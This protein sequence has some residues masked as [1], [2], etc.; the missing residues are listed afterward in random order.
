MPIVTLTTDFGLQ[1]WFVGSMRGVMLGINPDLTIVDL[2]HGICG[3]DIPGGALA[4]TAGYHCFPPG[5]IH[6]A[7]V[8]PGVGS[9]RTA[10]AASIPDHFFIGP[11][12]GLFALV[13]ARQGKVSLR[14][15]DDIRWH[16]HPVSSTFHGRDIFAPAAAHLSRGIPF[17]ALGSAVTS[18]QTLNWPSV[19]RNQ[20]EMRG[21]VVYVDHF[22]N[23]LTNIHAD[24]LGGEA[25]QNVYL[26][27]GSLPLIPGQSFYQ[28]VDCGC[29]LVLIGSSGYLE[30]AVNGGRACDHLGL[31]RESKV[32]LTGKF[33]PLPD[34]NKT[35]ND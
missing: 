24:H 9:E 23:C 20:S 30:I 2:T 11:D 12:N 22:G 6:V 32:V 25:I 8:D 19:T 4:L 7:V 3:G 21:A 31:R 27:I 13:L 17:E 15:L 5:T 16:R 10:L 29:P 18:F 34:K 1:D 28:E 26:S 14:R 33:R 35:E